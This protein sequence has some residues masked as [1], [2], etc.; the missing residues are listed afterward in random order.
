MWSRLTS[1][2][3]RTRANA[4]ASSFFKD[5]SFEIT[6]GTVILSVYAIDRYLVNTRENNDSNNNEHI[7]LQEE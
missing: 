3:T 7:K 6:L 4:K 2:F 1:T 5:G